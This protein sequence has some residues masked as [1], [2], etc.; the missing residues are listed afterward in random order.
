MKPVHS[1]SMRTENNRRG[2]W[3]QPSA[4]LR[5]W[6]LVFAWFL[7]GPALQADEV[8]I[9]SLGQNG[10]L[11]WSNATPNAT[12]RVEWAAAPTGPWHDSWAGLTDI[13]VTNTVTQREVP[14][15]YRL[16]C[17]L[18][19]VPLVTNINASA[20]LTLVQGHTADTNFTMLDVRTPAEYTPRHMRGALNLDFYASDFQARL[21]ELDRHRV[22]FVYCASGG[23]SGQTVAKMQ[24]LGF[25][26]V[27]NL[28]GGFGTFAAL[29]DAA[30]YLE[31]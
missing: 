5:L 25:M 4:W 28:N 29:P 30:P 17:V 31:P 18:P 22:Y 9:L 15:F 3:P 24:S 21:E 23:R 14:M 13:V 1:D 11:T 2:R 6:G 8:R 10:I 16:V 20:A 7:L 12:C 26:T 19:P 27:Y